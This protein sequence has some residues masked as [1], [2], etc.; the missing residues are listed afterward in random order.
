MLQ[1]IIT[2]RVRFWTSLSISN[3]TLRSLHRQKKTLTS[4]LP[5]F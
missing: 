3:T 4:F 5:L 2:E 1:F